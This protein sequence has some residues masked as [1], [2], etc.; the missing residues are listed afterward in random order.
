[1]TESIQNTYHQIKELYL[2]IDQLHNVLEPL[3][4][5]AD[6]SIELYSIRIHNYINRIIKCNNEK[7]NEFIH[8]EQQIH[9]YDNSDKSPEV[10]LE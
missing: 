3:I 9:Q 1:M 7:L 10:K 4:N 8:L 6:Q 2:H 5:Q